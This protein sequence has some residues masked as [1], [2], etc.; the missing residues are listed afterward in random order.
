VRRLS[1]PERDSSQ[2]PARAESERLAV[3]VRTRARRLTYMGGKPAQTGTKLVKPT[4]TSAR[5]LSRLAQNHPSLR[6]QSR[7][8]AAVHRL[9]RQRRPLRVV[10]GCLVLPG[11]A[12]I[13]L[14]VRTGFRAISC[15]EHTGTT[16]LAAEKHRMAYSSEQKRYSYSGCSGVDRGRGIGGVSN[17]F[18]DAVASAARRVARRCSSMSIIRAR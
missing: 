10:P 13:P 18:P 16:N 5:R 12:A 17:G 7:A 6:A 8:P 2:L 3:G 9:S 4:Q 11:P 15:C 14:R 1:P